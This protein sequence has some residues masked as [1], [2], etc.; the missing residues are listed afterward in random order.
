MY[1]HIRV[2]LNEPSD[3]DGVIEYFLLAFPVKSY[4]FGLE[5]AGDNNHHIHGHIEYEDDFDPTLPKNKVKRSEFFKKMKKMEFVPD[6]TESNYHEVCRDEE[7]NLAY[8]IKDCHVISVYNIDEATL[9]LA[10]N[11]VERIEG[12]KGLKIKE[13][14][15]NAWMPMQRLFTSRLEA[16]VF[17]DKYHV[18]RD[19]LPPNMSMKLQYAIYILH[20]T[21]KDFSPSAKEENKSYYYNF[22]AE[23]IN[24]NYSSNINLNTIEPFYEQTLQHVVPKSVVMGES[25]DL[26]TEALD[27]PL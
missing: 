22:Y 16:F 25:S 10:R 11:R 3:A 7:K 4:A 1:Y 18:D 13:Q 26:A 9:E 17:I 15:L 6:K 20:K 21:Y 27:T 19:Y 23:L 24:T 14:L 12:E 5:E 8:V 2:S